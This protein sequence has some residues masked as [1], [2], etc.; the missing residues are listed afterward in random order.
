MNAMA[1]IQGQPDSPETTDCIQSTD[2]LHTKSIWTALTMGSQYNMSLEVGAMTCQSRTVSREDL[3][4]KA[5][6]TAYRH[7]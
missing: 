1:I 2:H 3:G 4:S 5:T 6:K 7:P